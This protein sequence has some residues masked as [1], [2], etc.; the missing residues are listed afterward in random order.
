MTSRHCVLLLFN[1]LTAGFIYANPIPDVSSS[2]PSDPGSDS[3]S[4]TPSDPF[5]FGY[6]QAA[7]EEDLNEVRTVNA[8]KTYS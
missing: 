1:L 5:D 4:S 3:S 6:N 7:I 8:I 2:T